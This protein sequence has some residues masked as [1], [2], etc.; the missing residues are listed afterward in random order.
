[1]R[2]TPS[3]YHPSQVDVRSTTMLQLRHRAAWPVLPPFARALAR[4]NEKYLQALHFKA[5]RSPTTPALKTEPVPHTCL[6]STSLQAFLYFNGQTL[7]PSLPPC[8]LSPRTPCQSLGKPRRRHKKEELRP[9]FY[10]ALGWRRHFVPRPWLAAPLY[11]YPALGW[12]RHCIY[13][14]PLAGGA[15]QEKEKRAC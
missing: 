15:L 9:S 3:A 1:M 13:I 11:L 10:P 2:G 12:R 14:P 5:F 6:A 4:R 8:G 7:R